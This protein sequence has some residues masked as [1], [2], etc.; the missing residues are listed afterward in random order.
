MDLSK[1]FDRVRN[2]LLT[3]RTEWP[4]IAG[5]A[6]T[7]R[8][9]YMNYVLPL[10]ALAAL[11]A[12]L[13]SAVIGHRIP[14]IGT[15]RLGVGFSLGTAVLTFVMAFVTTYLVALVA[16][17]LA[18]S[19]GAE[20]NEVQATKAVAYA[21]TASWVASVLALLPWLG[22]LFVVAAAIY[23]IYLLY[24][25]LQ[26]CMKVSSDK[27]VGYTVVT[28]I[29]AIIAGWLVS[30]VVGMISATALQGGALGTA[31][32][33]A[34]TGDGTSVTVDPGSAVGAATAGAL[35]Q[36][37][38][39]VEE[40][41]K[42]AEVANKSGDTTAAV[43]AASGVLGAVL[44][45]AAAD[46]KVVEPLS[47]DAIKAVIPASLAGM[48]RRELSAERNAMG[49]FKVSV[50][51]AR[52]NDG[53]KRDIQ[54][55]VSDFG[56]ATGLMA[57]AGMAAAVESEKET[58]TGYEKNYHD[59]D[60]IVHEVWDRRDGRGEYT[61][62]SAKRYSVKVSGKAGSIDEL[63]SVAAAIHL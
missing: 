25:G 3:P 36:W 33:R 34:A 62:L 13:N 35:Q 2:V 60:R 43:A 52:F 24:L 28:C 37:S 56:G 19:F 8:Q 40:A 54:V 27:A 30:I 58:E 50:A 7:Q 51:H 9:I 59:G 4:L 45:G 61:V 26:H 57:L 39:R 49:G 55:E 29:V 12:F 6:T 11:C 5:E 17:A 53:A 23:G 16:N 31:L 14:F 44:G 63:K 41:G 42:K 21:Y 32:G 18:P 1:V 47:I 46:G 22:W 20:K 10:A 15:M 38:A 48:E